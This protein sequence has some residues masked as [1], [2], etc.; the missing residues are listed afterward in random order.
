[1]YKSQKMTKIAGGGN[2]SEKWKIENGKWGARFSIFTLVGLMSSAAM[3]VWYV[4]TDAED[5]RSWARASGWSSGALPTLTSESVAV[6]NATITPANPLVIPTGTDARASEALFGSSATTPIGLAMEDGAT[7]ETATHFLLGY[8]FG[9]TGVFTLNGGTWYCCSGDNAWSDKIGYWGT[10][11][12]TNNNGVYSMP[13]RATSR[14]L[15]LGVY[16]SNGGVNRSSGTWVQFGGEINGDSGNSIAVGCAGDGLMELYGGK[17]ADVSLSIGADNGGR[18]RV[19]I[20]GAET[21]FNK[22][23]IGDIAGSYGELEFRSG[24]LTNSS[25]V[26]GNSGEGRFDFTGGKIEAGSNWYEMHIGQASTGKGIVNVL[27]MPNY[28]TNSEDSFLTICVGDLGD[29]ELKVNDF[30]ATKYLKIGRG[31]LVKT[32]RATISDGQKL[33]VTARA[34]IGGFIMSDGNASAGHGIVE[35]KGGTL[36]V[37]GTGNKASPSLYLGRTQGAYGEIRGYGRVIGWAWDSNNLYMTFGNGKIVGDGYGEERIL[38]L[39]SVVNVESL[40]GL[41]N[42]ATGTNGWYA[43]NRGAVYFPRTWFGSGGTYG[44]GTDKTAATPDFVNSLKFTLASASDSNHLR[45]GVMATDRDDL[46]LDMLPRN[47]RVITCWKLGNFSDRNESESDMSPRAFSG[48]KLTFRYDRASLKAGDNIAMYRYASGGWKK[49]GTAVV[50][51]DETTPLIETA[52][53][54]SDGSQLYN[55]GIF[56]LVE[57]TPGFIFSIR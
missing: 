53:F 48:M 1:M 14:Q 51:D 5:G 38:D 41:A 24:S 26:V 57:P 33:W 7:L 15:K 40:A 12:V 20:D 47:L 46:H 39:T 3:A 42:S 54:D 2:L 52:A 45:G 31:G 21:A 9:N 56:A 10:G 44:F 6:N 28:S 32:G 18:G 25:L 8:N 11:I 36:S 55:A 49:V 23:N 4:P 43:V 17:V 29:A 16:T 35:L 30:L 50:G 19:L 34:D 37:N 27:K 22:I 13:K